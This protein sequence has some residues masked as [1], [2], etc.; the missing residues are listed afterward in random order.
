MLQPALPSY[1]KTVIYQKKKKEYIKALIK[2]EK[3]T[4]PIDTIV[5]A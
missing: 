1:A 4:S 3:C 5:K 2:K